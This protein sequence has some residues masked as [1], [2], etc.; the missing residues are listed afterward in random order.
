MN[1]YSIIVLK[2]DLECNFPPCTHNLYASRYNDSAINHD[3]CILSWLE[4]EFLSG[5]SENK[6]VVSSNGDYVKQT[7]L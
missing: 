2:W 4:K 1:A 7:A 5:L 6:C 3:S